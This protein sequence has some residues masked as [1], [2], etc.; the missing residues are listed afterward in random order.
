[1]FSIE[2]G[3]RRKK[4][5]KMKE[6][7]YHPILVRHCTQA[8]RVASHMLAYFL[9]CHQLQPS[10]DSV[11]IIIKEVNIQ[12]IYLLLYSEHII[13]THVKIRTW[14]KGTTEID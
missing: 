5:K 6:S 10:N 13:I 3:R 12:N 7:P 2:R 9:Q 14:I 4:G 8:K 1:M 11:D